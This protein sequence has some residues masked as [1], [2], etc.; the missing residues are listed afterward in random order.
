MLTD[1]LS[2]TGRVTVSNFTLIIR[3][4][5]LSLQKKKK[6]KKESDSTLRLEC[7]LKLFWHASFQPRILLLLLLLLLLQDKMSNPLV[8][9]LEKTDGIKVSTLN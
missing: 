1:P 7:L 6:G 9:G 2:F 8:V 3:F 5:L 4:I